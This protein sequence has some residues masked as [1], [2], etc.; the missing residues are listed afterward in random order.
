MFTQYDYHLGSGTNFL[1]FSADGLS[2]VK[3][4]Y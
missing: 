1:P 3:Q 4:S 2:R